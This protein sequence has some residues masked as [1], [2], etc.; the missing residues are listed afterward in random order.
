MVARDRKK[1]YRTTYVKL[2]YIGA[3]VC[4]L[5]PVPLI[6]GA[7]TENELLVVILLCVTMLIAGVGAMLFIVAGVRWASIQKLLREGE[8]SKNGKRKISEI[9]GTI[10]WLVVTAVYLCWSLLRNDWHITWVLWPVAG[11]LFVVVEL[12]CNLWLEKYEND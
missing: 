2:N 5:S 3:G 1:A 7:F 9:V 11:V 4:V 10:Y 6:T 12:I 8:F